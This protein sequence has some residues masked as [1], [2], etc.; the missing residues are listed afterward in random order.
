[1]SLR[2]THSVYNW[3]LFFA[4]HNWS[5]CHA[6][7]FS[8]YGHA[9]TLVLLPG[10]RIYLLELRRENRIPIAHLLPTWAWRF[11]QA[12]KSSLMESSHCKEKT[13]LRAILQE[14][15]MSLCRGLPAFGLVHRCAGSGVLQYCGTT[16]TKSHRHGR[17]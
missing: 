16:I 13:T 15:M 7:V 11:T 3:D 5:S 2:V 17:P 8:S 6:F 4:H 10:L 9:F 1:M 12:W 14:S